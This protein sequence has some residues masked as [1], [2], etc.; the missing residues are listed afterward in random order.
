[1][2][3]DIQNSETSLQKIAKATA[4]ATARAQKSP[5]G[6]GSAFNPSLITN[7]KKIKDELTEQ[8]K[9]AKKLK[10]QYDELGKTAADNFYSMLTGA[11]SFSD[12][13]KGIMNSILKS[14]YDATVGK[15]I[16]NTISN[17]LGSTGMLGGG[18]GGSSSGLSSIFSSI[19]SKISSVFGFADGGV[20]QGA[21]MFP[22]GSNTG[23]MGEAGAEA[24]MPLTRKGGKLGVANYGGGGANVT[25]NINISTGVSQTVRAELARMMPEIKKQSVAA[26][27]DANKRNRIN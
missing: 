10:D 24:I 16:S 21:T 23:V 4:D 12:G 17:L 26:W 14:V 9:A 5:Y 27:Q 20:I 8:E 6:G 25:Q 19:G 22:I 2:A 11:Q 13:F 1:V 3:S 7:S 18:S 15:S